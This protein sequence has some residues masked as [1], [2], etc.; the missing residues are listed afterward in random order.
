MSWRLW[1][2]ETFC[3]APDQ[4]DLPPRFAFRR[5][6]TRS[7]PQ[8][9]VPELS[10]SVESDA[11]SCIAP[12][13]CSIRPAPLPTQPQLRRNDSTNST[14]RGI[15]KHITPIDLQ[16]IVVS[17]KEKQ[18]LKDPLSP[19][20]SAL[21]IEPEPRHTTIPTEPE[22]SQHRVP[23]SSTSTV[24]TAINSDTSA[25]S[26]PIESDASSTTDVS[27]PHSVVRGF[28]PG[29]VCSSF[30]SNTQLAPQ[31]T[32]ILKTTPHN[33]RETAPPKRKG[34][35][36]VLGGSSGEGDE[37]SFETRYGRSA[38]S[39]RKSSHKKQTSFKEEVR[40]IPDRTYDS[41]EAI[42]S[43]S[44]DDEH[45]DSAIDDE[46]DEDDNNWEDDDEVNGE[47]EAADERE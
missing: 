4:A 21:Q 1:G 41:E 32:P 17:I 9:Q 10:S 28:Q 38:M 5:P 13:D 31:P 43:E 40:T 35:T 20:P 19:L 8:N 39:D 42:E 36:F 30:R 47:S 7:A 29:R 44:E 25:M 3:C 22:A 24:A 18:E 46:Y 23:E 11:S 45:A 34:A 26:P 14:H 16:K 37:S 12:D 6:K 15:Q 2:T 27:S 33:K